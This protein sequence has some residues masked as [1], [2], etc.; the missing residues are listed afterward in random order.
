MSSDAQALVQQIVSDGRQSGLD[1]S[2][3]S[4]NILY[5]LLEQGHISEMQ[6]MGRILGPLLG[7]DKSLHFLGGLIRNRPLFERVLYEVKGEPEVPNYIISDLDEITRIIILRQLQNNYKDSVNWE[8]VMDNPIIFG[9]DDYSQDEILDGVYI[10]SSGKGYDL[11]LYPQT[12]KKLVSSIISQYPFSE[13]SMRKLEDYAQQNGYLKNYIESPDILLDEYKRYPH[14]GG[15][16]VR[17]APTPNGPL[18]IGHGRGVSILSEYCDMYGMDLILRF[19]DTDQNPLKGSDL[20]PEF[21]IPD[22]YEW[23]EEDL[24]WIKGDNNFTIVR[25]SDRGNLEYYE[26]ITR[27]LINE[28]LAFVVYQLGTQKDTQAFV[29]NTNKDLN[30]RLLSLMEQGKLDL[31]DEFKK[32]RAINSENEYVE[33][34]GDELVFDDAYVLLAFDSTKPMDIMNLYLLAQYDVGAVKESMREALLTSHMRKFS[35][36]KA[37]RGTT[38]IMRLQKNQNKR[39]RERGEVQY[40]W[41]TL[42]LQAPVDDYRY[43]VTHNIRGPDYALKDTAVKFEKSS[44]GKVKL[45]GD[46]QKNIMNAGMQGIIYKLIGGKAMNDI[47]TWGLVDADGE[48]ISTSKYK[49]KIMSGEL[50]PYSSK[51]LEGGFRN[52][53][54]PTIYSI[55]SQPGMEDW[56]RIFRTYWTRFKMPLNLNPNFSSNEFDSYTNEIFIEYP[57]PQGLIED[58]KEIR[59]AITKLIKRN[60][61]YAEEY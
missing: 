8:R 12:I 48:S 1:N 23:I 51:N 37:L 4:E 24:E 55:R 56:G 11:S 52:P 45:S 50:P 57:T 36:L 15:G 58:D 54:I 10:F 59:D 40:I 44:S 18:S 61:Y 26:K 41:P 13:E 33:L 47:V 25:A 38:K 3:I 2:K 30:L 35:T 16:V 42:R 9:A 5:A 29:F 49:R 34:M 14:K 39:V 43:N 17:F 21:G 27:K 60:K 53:S 20:P 46:D 19:D 28:G 7:R 32:M 6:Q 22:V 31:T